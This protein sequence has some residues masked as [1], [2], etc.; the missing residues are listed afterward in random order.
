MLALIVCL[1][2][3]IAF[4]P[5]ASMTTVHAAPVKAYSYKYVELYSRK[6]YCTMTWDNVNPVLQDGYEIIGIVNEGESGN[7]SFH[8]SVLLRK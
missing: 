1:L 2:A 3:I 5:Q 7:C 6:E 8:V 4:K